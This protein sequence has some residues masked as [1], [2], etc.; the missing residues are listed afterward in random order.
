MVFLC[1]VSPT[2]FSARWGRNGDLC[3]LRVGCGMKARCDCPPPP[4][5]PR[6]AGLALRRVHESRSGPAHPRSLMSESPQP[7][8]LTQ[9]RRLFCFTVVVLC[10]YCRLSQL[11]AANIYFVSFLRTHISDFSRFLLFFH[12]LYHF[13]GCS[14][15]LVG[16]QFPKQ[17]KNPGLWQ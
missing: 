11:R 13:S 3:C 1:H 9:W 14:A 2:A 7:A 16:Y 6:E 12:L 8:M 5:P 4:T 17:G 10:N 15:Q